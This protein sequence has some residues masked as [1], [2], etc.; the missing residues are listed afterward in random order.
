[1]KRNLAQFFN[2][3][4]IAVVG[5]SNTSGKVGNI[6]FNNLINSN[7]SGKIFP[8]NKS[9]K[10]VLGKESYSNLLEVPEKLDL[11]VL[12]VPASVCLS[13]LPDIESLG[14]SNVIFLAA[15]F[16]EIGE[17]GFENE[18]KLQ[19]FISS[20]KFNILGPN[21][22]GYINQGLDLNLT[23]GPSFIKKGKLKIVTQSG[24]IISALTDYA[25]LNAFGVGE[26][27]TLGNKADINEND[28]LDYL[29]EQDLNIENCS[30]VGLYLE[31]IL[32][33]KNFI[34]KIKR[35]SQKVPVFILKPG[36]LSETSNALKSHTGSLIGEY[37]VFSQI[38][39]SLNVIVCDSLSEF[40]NFCKLYS[41]SSFKLESKELMILSNAGGPS[42]LAV[43]EL[44]SNNFSLNHLTP[45]IVTKL[46]TVLPASASFSNPLDL[47]GDANSE[48]ISK[49]FEILK[50]E[51]SIKNYIV[52]LTPQ[53]S[54]DFEKIVD[55]LAGLKKNH[56]VFVVLLGGAIVSR[57]S[58]AL[59]ALRIPTFDY[60]E[61]LIKVLHK[62]S[63]LDFNEERESLE[64]FESEVQKNR[65]TGKKFFE[66]SATCL[67]SG[68]SSLKNKRAES[69]LEGFGIKFPESIES[70]N[71]DDILNFANKV[72]YP[73][74]LKASEEGLIHKKNYGGLSF[75]I[76][77]DLE[78]KSEFKKINNKF[79]SIQ[80]QKQ[81]SSGLELILGYKYD[82]TFGKI[83]QLGA[84]GEYVD[85]ISDKNIGLFPLS[86]NQISKLI[87]N[88]K[89]ISL[90]KKEN[91]D[92][93]E[94]TNLI[95]K[96][97]LLCNFANKDT[98]IE[99][100]PII[101]RK[102][103]VT[104]VD[105]K[106]IYKPQ[107][108]KLSE[109]IKFRNPFKQAKVLRNEVLSAKF[110]HLVFKCPDNWDF[111]P[112]QYLN[113]KVADKT[114]RS[115]SIACIKNSNNFELLIDT[116][117]QG[118]G[119]IYFENLKVGDTS[120]FMGPFGTFI[121]NKPEANSDILF[122][123]TGSG[124]TPLKSM[125]DSALF[126]KKY[127]NKIK[128]YFG[129]TS[130]TE[131]F[132]QDYFEI[133]TKKF[134]NFSVEYAIFTPSKNWKGFKGYITDLL[135]RDYQTCHPVS[136]YLCGHP[137]MM[138]SVT[139]LLLEKGCSNDKIYIERYS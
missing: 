13:L 136:A 85:V 98:E 105:V 59:N 39:M 86:K 114:Y 7:Y 133:L 117:P 102:D 109:P 74:V 121:L 51:K 122:F 93:E 20:G 72:G 108:N 101:L 63:L 65:E 130:D 3:K 11:V 110:R 126:E 32:D 80:I 106:V 89:I 61:H 67:N 43:D 27:I 58:H 91:I 64:K 8:I 41:F 125:I 73:V 139:K 115:Y 35:I 66:W 53:N 54:T 119:S 33:G 135:K 123:A 81:V 88:S 137:A 103:G 48:R 29:L 46:K 16:K 45:E 49:A 1:M 50:E 44:Y 52:I 99:I 92:I 42:V 37:D 6:V 96:F 132:W 77:N 14:I 100:N 57:F 18:K 5:A 138:E 19:N 23:F 40:F 9:E 75:N 36:R 87:Q 34:S 82:S 112:G 90:I 111:L 78:L 4:S 79:K 128:L 60:F 134:P 28:I 15:G 47:V 120:T 71:Y 70:E 2:P 113:F 69:F 76:L 25:N 116:K 83:I 62:I 84:G 22:F 124:I 131:I 55:I 24:A 127:Q 129:F 68:I 17:A 26:V 21:C 12:A 56:N 10:E 31:S 38:M 107:S 97:Q 104:P 94:L 118:P 30:G 95:F